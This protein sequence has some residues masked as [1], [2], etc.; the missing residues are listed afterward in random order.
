MNDFVGA[1]T[2]DDPDFW[3]ATYPVTVSLESADTYKVLGWIEEP[4]YY[5]LIKIDAAALTATVTK[6]VYG[7]TLPT[8]PYTNPAAEGTDSYVLDHSNDQLEALMKDKKF[9]TVGAVACDQNGN[10]AAATST[11][12]M[13]N[14]KYGRIGDTP[15]IGSGTYA[16]NATC[17]ISCTGHGELFIRAV[18]AYDVSAIMEYKNLDLQQAMDEVVNN[19]LVKIGGEG[20]MIGVD[21]AGNYALMFNSEVAGGS[22]VRM[23]ASMPKQFLLLR[24]KAVLW[25]TLNAFLDAF[26][27]VKI[28]LVLPAQHI[29]TGKEI[30]ATLAAPRRVE[31]TAGGDTRY[32]SVQKGLQLVEKDA[33]VFVHDGVRCLVTP[34]LIQ[35]CYAAAVER[36]NATPAIAAVDSIRIDTGTG[37]EVMDRNRVRIIQTPQTFLAEQLLKAFEQPYEPSF[38]DEATVVER[39]GIAIH[40][41]EGRYVLSAA[42]RRDG[43]SVWAP[44]KKWATFPS[45]SIGWRIDQEDFMKGMTK[46]SELKVRAGYGI[47][48][49]NGV[50]LGNTPWQVSV[51]SNS[52]YYPY[53]NAITGGPA[54]SIQRLGNKDLEWEKTKQ[55]NVGLDLGLLNN[56]FTLSAEYYRRQ[57]DNLIL[58]V[59]LPPSFGFITSTVAQNVG[60]MRN[61]GFEVQLGYNDR[62]G[63]FKW[64]AS[65][66]MS[67]VTNQNAAEVASHATQV[68]A[69]APGDIKFKDQN[70]DGVI[71]LNDRVFLG[72]FIPKMTY[73]G[74]Q[75]NKIYNA[76]RVITE[77]MI[78]FFNAGTQ[79]L[80]IY[81]SAQNILTVTKY[82]GFDPEV[83]N[84]T[85]GSSQLTNGIDFA[86]YPQPKAFQVGI[87]AGF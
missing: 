47:T 36:G 18:A 2:V 68:A 67:F 20:G 48:G 54:S 42:V 35:R 33:V 25:H 55:F 52:A 37:N 32:Q 13:T 83:G 17:A 43:L 10:L 9:G 62:I 26:T 75:G 22:G 34:A 63:D 51:S 4:S 59:P 12:G 27:D 87:Q 66:N 7:P 77:G 40:L 31:I 69:T 84:R 23:G 57:T 5:I 78:R 38:T 3:G 30:I 15:V 21:A 81:V 11:G 24:N 8:T 49:I 44:G 45:G 64:N 79:N 65:A 72:S 71:D 28:I 80:R 16:N 14:K 85:P 60:A 56:A 50:L 74:V 73:A 86:V 29:E 1:A 82:K 53:N 61:S 6:R 39:M 58:N 19:K 41:V 76:T 46:I 70:K